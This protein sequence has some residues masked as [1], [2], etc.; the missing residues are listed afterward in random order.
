MGL[1]LFSKRPAIADRLRARDLRTVERRDRG[2]GVRDR[3]AVPLEYRSLRAA[4]VKTCTLHAAGD[5]DP[6][7]GPVGGWS[8]AVLM[9][10]IY[11]DPSL[12][13]ANNR[14]DLL[15]VIWAQDWTPIADAVNGTR[16]ERYRLRRGA[17]SA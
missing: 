15:W 2:A 8:S 10:M 5:P 11:G 1:F 12:I 17:D 7:A 4:A 6:A 9:F 14:R 13:G 16:R 3:N